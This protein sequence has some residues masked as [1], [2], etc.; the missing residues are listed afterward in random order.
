MLGFLGIINIT[1]DDEG[2]AFHPHVLLHSDLQNI[3]VEAK[4]ME[5]GMLHIYIRI[6]PSVQG[7]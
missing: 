2:L 6:I 4:E 7:A 3:S 5:E 1:E